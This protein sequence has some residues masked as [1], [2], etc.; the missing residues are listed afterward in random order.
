MMLLAL[1]IGFANA[2]RP[3]DGNSNAKLGNRLLVQTNQE[4]DKIVAVLKQLNAVLDG[5][6]RNVGGAGFKLYKTKGNMDIEK[7]IALLKKSGF[8][9]EEDGILE[10]NIIPN[11]ASFGSLWGMTKISAPAAWDRFVGNNSI[12]V[13]VIDTGVQVA[14]P[15]LAVNIVTAG[16]NAITNG[17]GAHDDNNHGTH[18]TGTIAAVGNNNIG[19]VGVAWNAKILPCKFMN[20]LGSG[21]TSDAIECIQYCRKNGAKITS[22][23]WG[24]GAYSSALYN[25]ILNE[26]NAGNLFIAA[27]GNANSNLDMYPSYPAAYNLDN[28]IAVGATTSTDAR[29]SYSNFGINNVDIMAPGDM[30]YSTVRGNGYNTLSAHHVTGAAALLWQAAPRLSYSQIRNVLMSSVDTVA[31][32]GTVCKSGGRLNVNKALANAI[33]LSATL[34]A[35]SPTMCSCPC[36]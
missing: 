31:G 32:L 14:H 28:I 8:E 29:A 34:P 5:N 16:Y 19:V 2:G 33:S 15:D 22:N 30:I 4:D 6:S 12:T 36:S 13:C 9:A 7:A 20:Y 18:V 1:A 21:Y 3:I 25:E 23:S 27:A 10:V 35:P 24:G 26:R 17:A 11:D